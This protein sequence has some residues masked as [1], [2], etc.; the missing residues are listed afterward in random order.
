MAEKR[1]GVLLITGGQTHQETYALAFAAD[2]RVRLLAVSDETNI[3]ARRR[4]LNERLAKQLNIPT[5]QISAKLWRRKKWRS[6]V[7]AQ[8]QSVVDKLPNGVLKQENTCI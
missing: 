5:F 2:P 6:L 4:T 1:Y 8:S 3:S 7:F